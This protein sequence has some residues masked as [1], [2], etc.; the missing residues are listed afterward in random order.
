MLPVVA[1]RRIE[2]LLRTYTTDLNKVS[3]FAHTTKK[4]PIHIAISREFLESKIG[5]G[6]DIQDAR[7]ILV[8]LGFVVQGDIQT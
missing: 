1:Q 7:D 4:D 6:V 5:I 3:S 2:Q 8:R